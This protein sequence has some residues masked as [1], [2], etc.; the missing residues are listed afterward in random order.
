VE[1]QFDPVYVPQLGATKADQQGRTQAVRA[2]A[3]AALAS[4]SARAKLPRKV[5]VRDPMALLIDGTPEIYHL[6]L[7]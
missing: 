3:I 6:Q 4:T 7:L 2:S 5:P 1:R